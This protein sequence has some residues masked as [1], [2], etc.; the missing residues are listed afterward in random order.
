MTVAVREA[1]RLLGLDRP[2][3]ESTIAARAVLQNAP[4]NTTQT[5]LVD[6]HRN[7]PKPDEG[8]LYGLVGDVGKAAAETTEANRFAVAAGFLSFLSAAVGRDVYIPV[9]NTKHHA[10]LFTLQVGRTGR[11]RKGDAMS[12]V[13]RVRQG[14]EEQHCQRA[15][16][17]ADPFC[18]GH[19][20]GGLS[21]REGLALLIHDGYKNGKDEVPAILDKRLWVVES[22]FANVLHQAKRDGNTLSAALRDAWDGISIR[23]ATKTA[24]LWASDP[25][26]ALSAAITPSELLNLMN[27][28]ELS[29]GFANRFLIFW[30]ERERIEPFPKPTHAAVVEELVRRTMEVIRFAKGEYPETTNSR[31]LELSAD[32]QVEY[33][34]L[35]RGELS[36]VADGEKVTA[37]LER[38][39]PMLLR[40]AM[41]FALTDLVMVIEVHHIHAALAWTQFHRDSVR[42]IFDDAAGED[43]AR[44]ST[45]AAG[46]ILDYLKQHGRT[47]RRDLLLKCF[48]GHLLA[49]RLDEALDSLL[50]DSPPAIEMIEGDRTENGK[51]PKFY[52]LLN[53]R[54]LANLPI[55][56]GFPQVRGVANLANLDAVQ[57]NPDSPGY[58]SSQVSETAET[59]TN[60]ASSPSYP[61]SHK[62]SSNQ[63]IG[64]VL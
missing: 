49:Q 40:L 9:G 55:S 36:A 4:A 34:R 26:I 25:H 3:S 18:G 44:E 38:R 29:N 21:T 63:I 46:K 57:S 35:Y 24:R 47:G 6:F 64:V 32:A 7:A 60:R 42:F 13:Q 58:P 20:F 5:D 11:G 61:S 22:E 30:A 56:T 14:I 10:R 27:S 51:L 53:P 39:A 37:L 31:A 33:A 50:M 62:A 1:A 19:H 48:S 17:V 43:A 52:Q 23:P 12:L 16:I 54:E 59:R 2:A 41:L 8:M 15:G 28:R 45:D